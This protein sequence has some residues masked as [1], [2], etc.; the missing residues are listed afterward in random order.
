[1]SKKKVSILI[2]IKLIALVIAVLG[3]AL[4]VVT[5]IKEI[6]FPV[7]DAWL[8][9]LLQALG[10]TLASAGLVSILIECSTIKGIMESAIK[11]VLE[12]DID[13]SVYSQKVLKR[14]T[15]DIAAQRCTPVKN[16]EELKNSLYKNEEKIIEAI[17][18]LYY[19]YHNADFIIE[20]DGDRFIKT[21]KL[22]Y[23]II[24]KNGY[25][26][27]VTKTIYLFGDNSN[28]SDEERRKKFNIKKLIVNGEDY[29]EEA[30]N[31]ITIKTVERPKDSV[32][33][34]V[35]SFEKKI[36]PDIK[37]AKVEMVIEYEVP[38]TDLIHV[39]KMI[40][41]CKNAEHNIYIKG[42]NW[43]LDG[44]AFAE[45]DC[46]YDN[47]KNKCAIK[48]TVSNN[49]KVNIKDWCMPGAGYITS[50]KHID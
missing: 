18:G 2:N 9:N 8:K 41:P 15:Y 47:E 37:K 27:K 13:Y 35:V 4:L 11:S 22:N 12:G 3:V 32:Y 5:S 26:N 25:D 29:T 42:D 17:N 48:Q 33:K 1:M 7:W 14:M 6:S 40:Y 36:D 46:D 38:I 39:Y 43:E 16:N 34:Y 31:E 45:F 49:I 19:E 30:N 20:Y 21:A 50:Y 44:A 10:T 24:N 28:I 23:V